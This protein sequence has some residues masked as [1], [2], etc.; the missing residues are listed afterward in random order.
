MDNPELKLAN[1]SNQSSEPSATTNKQNGLPSHPNGN[2]KKSFQLKRKAN[3]NGES[4]KNKLAK[5]S[6]K[7][8]T[9]ISSV[10]PLD[11]VFEIITSFLGIR[12]VAQSFYEILHARD[13]KMTNLFSELEFAYV[14]QLSVYYRC[15]RIANECKTAF[16]PR[17]SDLK[18]LI[19]GLLLPDCIA[20][21]VE[22][23]GIVKL[24]NG[25]SVCP[26]FRNH[27]TMT[28]TVGFVDLADTLRSINRERQNYDLPP[29]DINP[30]NWNINEEI[31]LKYARASSRALKNAIELRPV[32]YNNTEGR[33]EFL[34]VYEVDGR[35]IKCRSFDKI[36]STQCQLGACYR[37]RTAEMMQEGGTQFPV[38]FGTDNVRPDVHLNYHFIRALRN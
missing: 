26:Y 18:T 4:G 38:L 12:H 7:P 25:A 33:P 13:S 29:L 17:L 6:K 35:H 20:T 16:L 21:F 10:R 2:R 9:S 14:I 15:A 36:D 34:T 19:D 32:D 37:L 30:D 28:Q 5:F 23:F 3:F 8:E 11:T 24:T 31:V 22:T 1:E 27:A